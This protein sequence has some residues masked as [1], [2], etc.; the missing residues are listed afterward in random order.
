MN[1]HMKS[2]N[3]LILRC[4]DDSRTV[5]KSE[6]LLSRDLEV[7]LRL[8]LCIHYKPHIPKAAATYFI[9]SGGGWMKNHYG[10]FFFFS[11]SPCAGDPWVL[12]RFFNVSATLL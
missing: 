8:V 4:P 9:L 3:F 6:R 2:S 7:A 5:I 12:G 1:F 11:L 10:L